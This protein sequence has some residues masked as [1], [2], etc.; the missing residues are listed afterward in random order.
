[1]RAIE[2]F[3]FLLGEALVALRRN[4]W[5]S[6][7]AI[8]TS[9]ISLLLLGGLGYAYFRLQQYANTLPDLFEIRIFLVMDAPKDKLSDIATQI[10]AIPGVK[11]ARWISSTQAWE[12]YRIEMPEVTEG[13]ENPL[14]EGFNIKLTNLDQTESVVA[15]LQEVP[16]VDANAIDY[17]SREQEAVSQILWLIRYLGTLLGVLLFIVA[18]VLIHN[19]IRLGIIARRREI[20]I[21]KLCGASRFTVR[22]P[23]LLEG[24][25][26]GGVGGA[27]AAM[28]LWASQTAITQTTTQVGNTFRP[29]EPFPVLFMTLLL[30]GCGI[31]YG[32]ICSALAAR[33]PMKE[34]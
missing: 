7:A 20:R 2:H 8:T 26:Q 23:L 33:E 25:I 34:R 15:A 24:A 10:R 6:F 28:L 18:G 19:A 3:Q 31:G 32:L 4:G 5:M 9:A 13:L 11:E 17:M 27:A 22:T 30:T 12:K 29:T 14:P 21:M 1:M 16:Y